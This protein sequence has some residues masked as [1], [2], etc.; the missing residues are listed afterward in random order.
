MIP[1]QTLNEDT[2][3]LK[4]IIDRLVPTILRDAC[5]I[6]QHQPTNPPPIA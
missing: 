3:V 1:R 6:T 4:G 5:S 2:F